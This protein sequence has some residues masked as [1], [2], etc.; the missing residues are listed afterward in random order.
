M[1]GASVKAEVV[2]HGRHA[3]IRGFI[4]KPKKRFHRHF[5]HRQP[6]T[7]IRITDIAV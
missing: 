5:G 7:E 1:D 6:Y 2:S 3:H 4:Y